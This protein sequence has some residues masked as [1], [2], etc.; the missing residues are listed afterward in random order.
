[1]QFYPAHQA[2]Q[3]TKRLGF[4]TFIKVDNQVHEAFSK[5]AMN[6]S[7]AIGMNE[8]EIKEENS[9]GKF[10]IEVLYYT[11]PG[12]DV[13]GL[14]R[15]VTLK[16]SKSVARDFEFV[17]GMAAV[18]P[19]GVD[20][21]SINEMGQTSKAWIRCLMPIQDVLSL[22]CGPVWRIMQ[23]DAVRGQLWSSHKS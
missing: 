14:V 20:L 19:Y 1:M 22:R 3:N 10:D 8:L 5:E 13:A 12:E 2:Y 23:V 16:N 6:H 11:L 17:D 21:K 9:E 4:R 7:M 15:K 18:L